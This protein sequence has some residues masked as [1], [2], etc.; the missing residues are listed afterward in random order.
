MAS[1]LNPQQQLNFLT[2]QVQEQS[3]QIR[4]LQLALSATTSTHRPKPKP[5]LPDPV[6]FDSKSYHFDTWLP[7]IKAKLRVDDDALG[8]DIARFY[9]VYNRLESSVQSQ[10]LPQLA[11]AK[12]DEAWDYDT[13]LQQLA[14]AL[15]NPNRIQEAVEK[16]HSIKQGSDESLANYIAKFERMLYEAKGHKWDDDR[17][18]TSF[19]FGLSSTLKNRLSQQLEL[20]A[21]YPAFLK[22]VQKLSSRASAYSSST[23][24]SHSEG[25]ALYKPGH[26]TNHDAMDVSTISLNAINLSYDDQSLDSAPNQY[27]LDYDTALEARNYNQLGGRIS[28]KE[29]GACC[30]CG[31]LNHWVRNCPKPVKGSSHLTT[32]S[33]YNLFAK[34]D[35][36]NAAAAA[37]SKKV[38]I[39]APYDNYSDESDSDN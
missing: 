15:D 30:R 10:V 17:K 7:S 12:A 16:L 4:A 18:I 20:P 34:A 11:N 21:S 19:R 5:I 23:S 2:E 33:V 32:Q 14:R 22:T 26:S 38:T 25:R 27:A 28:Y 31:S 29:Q 36:D 24:H 37:S 35:A 8:D 13:I 3:A 1:N 39:V 6:K 9:Y